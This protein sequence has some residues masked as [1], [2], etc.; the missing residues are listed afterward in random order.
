MSTVKLFSRVGPVEFSHRPVFNTPFGPQ[1]GEVKRFHF[2]F[3]NGFRMEI[4][5]EVW[6]SIEHEF[7]DRK[8]R[9]TYK[10]AF[11]EL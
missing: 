11:V 5:L 8:N 3:E 9:I 7:I 6:E 2:S 10:E 4:P 1:Y